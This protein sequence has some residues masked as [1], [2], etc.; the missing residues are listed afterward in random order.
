MNDL[1]KWDRK[2]LSE[3]GDLIRGRRFTKNDYVESGL[4]CIHYAQ[5]HTDFGA[6]ARDPLTFLSEDSRARMR[7]AHSGN[8]VIAGT[9]ENVEDVGKAVAWMGDDGVAVHDDC[10]IFRHGLDPAYVSYF[11]GRPC[12]IRRSSSTY[13]RR[14]SCGSRERIW[15]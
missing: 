3:V 4:G 1:P 10:Y 6:I 13:P 8:L 12:S 2:P 5:I 7:L 11:L 9:S 14:K 15:D